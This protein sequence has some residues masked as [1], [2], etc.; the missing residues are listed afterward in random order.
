MPIK[1]SFAK[2]SVT[3][4]VRLRLFGQGRTASAG[5]ILWGA[6]L[7]TVCGW[8]VADAAEN[9]EA[10]G[11]EELRAL[12]QN[13]GMRR[14]STASAVYDCR[15]RPYTAKQVTA[16]SHLNLLRAHAVYKRKVLLCT[17]RWPPIHMYCV[18]LLIRRFDEETIE[19][20]LESTTPEAST[21]Q[22]MHDT[23]GGWGMV[24]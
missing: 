15:Y 6:V 12:A 14:S 18:V 13:G 9:G 1:V 11:A 10:E 4:V 7:K 16:G 23:P 20:R 21:V 22:Q 2:N 8:Q 24:A 5:E 17:R 3:T 19:E